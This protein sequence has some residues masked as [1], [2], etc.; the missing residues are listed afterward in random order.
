MFRYL[1]SLVVLVLLSSCGSSIKTENVSECPKSL[2]EVHIGWNGGDPLSIPACKYR[3][4]SGS[5]SYTP[6]VHITT[7]E[8]IREFK[9]KGM[10]SFHVTKLS[11][12]ETSD[13]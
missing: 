2:M 7:V 5:S 1:A 8:G 11:E 13:D 12:K 6:T 4:S 10:T 3:I 9:L